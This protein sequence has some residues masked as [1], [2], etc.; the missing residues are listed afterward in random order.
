MTPRKKKDTKEVVGGGYERPDLDIEKSDIQFTV[1]LWLN[2][3]GNPPS[4]HLAIGDLIARP[5]FH[6]LARLI[7]PL[8]GEAMSKT[9]LTATPPRPPSVGDREIM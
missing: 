5:E 1:V 9:M 6:D 8:M 3:Q 2:R 7:L 4:A